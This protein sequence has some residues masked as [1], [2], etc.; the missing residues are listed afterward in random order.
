MATPAP[1]SNGSV[2]LQDAPGGTDPLSFDSLFPPEPTI[3]APQAQPTPAEVAPA[4][5]APTTA[6]SSEE[7]FL[8]APTGTIYKTREAA[9]EGISQKDAL[10]EQMRQRYRLATGIDPISN[11]PLNGS[12]APQGPVNYAQDPKRFAQEVAASAEE[13]STNPARYRDTWT[14]FIMD[15]LEP[16]AP[17]ITATAQAQA[18]ERTASEIKDFPEFRRSDA[19]KRTLD[20]LPKLKEAI[21]MSEADMRLQSN[22]PDLYKMAYLTSKGMQL[23]EAVQNAAQHP[24]TPQ[25]IRTTTPTSTPAP[26]V[27]TPAPSLDTREGRKAIIEAAKAK[28]LDNAVW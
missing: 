25:P 15:V 5:P 16:V 21:E 23:P 7:P 2:N 8:R 9:I 26:A 18:V 24:T 6:P 3:A 10:I 27:P 22:L 4:P 14:K 19:Y 13:V 20:S 12:T 28:N 11:Q 1:G 17:I